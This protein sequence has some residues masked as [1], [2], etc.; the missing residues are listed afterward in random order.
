MYFVMNVY[1]LIAWIYMEKKQKLELQN[2]KT[3]E[4]I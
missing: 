2:K 4:N 1:G 3:S